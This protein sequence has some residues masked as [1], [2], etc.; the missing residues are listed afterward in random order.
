MCKSIWQRVRLSHVVGCPWQSY[1]QLLIIARLFCHHRGKSRR[2]K[3]LCAVAVD[4]RKS[5]LSTPTSHSVRQTFAAPA[6]VAVS[7]LAP[8]NNMAGTAAAARLTVRYQV[9]CPETS[10]CE[11]TP[12]TLFRPTSTEMQPDTKA[13]D[14]SCMLTAHTHCAGSPPPLAPLKQ[15]CFDDSAVAT[16]LR[17]EYT[18]GGADPGTPSCDFSAVGD[19]VGRW[20]QLQP[21][22]TGLT[23]LNLMQ[24]AI[25]CCP[26][27]CY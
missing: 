3:G 17:A 11:C 22:A 25:R 6:N 16:T 2:G 10:M 8:S 14:C 13:F 18:E 23:A 7:S 1:A 4:L 24:R 20:A 27:T 19:L 15:A 9:S 26:L 12:T 5:L 21:A